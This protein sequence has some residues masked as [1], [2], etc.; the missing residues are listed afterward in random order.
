MA[1]NQYKNY[2]KQ[3]RAYSH[4]WVICHFICFIAL[5]IV[6]FLLDGIIDDLFST[7]FLLTNILYCC[8]PVFTIFPVFN[9]FVQHHHLFYLWRLMSAI[10][11]HVHWLPQMDSLYIQR[12][13][14]EPLLLFK[15]HLCSVKLLLFVMLWMGWYLINIFKLCYRVQ[16]LSRNVSNSPTCTL[17]SSNGFPIYSKT[18]TRTITAF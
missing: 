14:Q 15:C 10:P 5:N 11:Q 7:N 1:S 4:P 3:G 17:T 8:W 6:H 13:V 9:L 2:L 18:C 12:H 16:Y